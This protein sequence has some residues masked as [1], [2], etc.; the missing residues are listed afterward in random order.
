[1]WAAQKRNLVQV[2]TSPTV[3]LAGE[4]AW[5]GRIDH[6]YTIKACLADA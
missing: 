1:M 4:D 2:Y 3:G 5:E 6:D